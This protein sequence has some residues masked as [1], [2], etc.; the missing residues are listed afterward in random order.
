MVGSDQ[1]QKIFRLHYLPEIIGQIFFQIA[2]IFLK[3]ENSF[4]VPKICGHT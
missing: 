4:K 3:H 2:Q 1:K